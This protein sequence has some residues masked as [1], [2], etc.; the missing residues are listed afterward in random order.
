VFLYV[1]KKGEVLEVDCKVR[2]VSIR[3]GFE[4]GDGEAVL[5]WDGGTSFQYYQA[6]KKT[7]KNYTPIVPLS[8]WTIIY[9]A[10]MQ[11][12][13]VISSILGLRSSCTLNPCLQDPCVCVWYVYSRYIIKFIFDVPLY[14][15]FTVFNICGWSYISIV[16]NSNWSRRILQ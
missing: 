6:K 13:S 16:V 14:T 1:C 2:G 7:K 15:W 5:G 11:A 9:F 4:A 10:S 8:D 3:C 12:N